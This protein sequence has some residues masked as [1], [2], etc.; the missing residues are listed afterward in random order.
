MENNLTTD[1]SPSKELQLKLFFKRSLIM[2]KI[3]H[4]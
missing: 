3:Q 4:G 2:S 1:C